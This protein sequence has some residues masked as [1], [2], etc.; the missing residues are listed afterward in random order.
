MKSSFKEFLRTTNYSFFDK[1]VLRTP[2]FPFTTS[3]GDPEKLLQLYFSSTVYQEAIFLASPSL[4]KRL[5]EYHSGKEFS[6]KEKDL[7]INAL[8]K[9]MIRMHSRCVPFGLFSGN[10]VLDWGNETAISIETKVPQRRIRPDMIVLDKIIRQ[11]ILTPHIKRELIFFPNNSIYSVRG[12]VRFVE[13]KLQ[14]NKRKYLVSEIANG[15]SVD[16]ILKMVANGERYGKLIEFICNEYDCEEDEATA[17]LDTLIESQLIVSELEPSSSGPPVL[18]TI[19]E[20]LSRV[21]SPESKVLKTLIETDS[22]FNL[23]ENDSEGENIGLY[24]DVVSK[25]LN[26]E[27][28]LTEV[29]LFQ[30]DSYIR[31]SERTISDKIQKDIQKGLYALTMLTDNNSNDN[32][33]V[34]ASKFSEVYEGQEVMLTD[35]MDSEIGLGYPINNLFNQEVNPLLDG[36]GI[37]GAQT[38]SSPQISWSPF[39][40]FLSDRI[41]TALENGEKIKE[42]SLSEVDLNKFDQNK[43]I[44]LPDTFY[45]F[46]RLCKSENPDVEYDLFLNFFAGSSGA[47]VISRFSDG[48]EEIH[49]LCESIGEYEELHKDKDSV[50]CELI[51][52]PETRNVN[53][54]KHK[55]FRSN[56]IPFLGKSSKKKSE[57][58]DINDL[59]LYMENGLLK[60]KSKSLNKNV[61]PKFSN[62]YNTSLSSIPLFRFLTD[63]RFYGRSSNLNISISS[64]ES[65][66]THLPRISFQNIILS[67]EYWILESS[68]LIKAKGTFTE[69]VRQWSEKRDIPSTFVIVQGDLE[70]PI[71]IDCPVSIFTF[72]SFVKKYPYLKICELVTPFNGVKN[73]DGKVFSNEFVAPMKQTVPVQSR[74]N[75][76]D[77]TTIK[78]TFIPGSEWLFYKIYCNPQASDNILRQMLHPI[79][80]ELLKEGKIKKWFFIRFTDPD[81]HL[82]FR[83]ELSNQSDYDYILAYCNEHFGES[84]EQSSIQNIQIAT[85]KREMERYIPS[86]IEIAEQ[87]FH[88]DSATICRILSLCETEEQRWLSG[89]FL[90]DDFLSSFG[91]TVEQKQKFAKEISERF[92][93]EFNVGTGQKQALNSR[94][95]SHSGMIEQ[96][97]QNPDESFQKISEGRRTILASEIASIKEH[98]NPENEIDLLFSYNHM[99]VNRLFRTRQRANE[100]V[101]YYF[102]HKFY[103]S[104]IARHSKV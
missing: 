78:R 20:L 25:L 54:L 82:R 36:L 60:L 71:D 47:D 10:S 33:S 39:L 44:R 11:I 24:Q 80:E 42:I 64:L 101:I 96:Q 81:Y 104:S 15:E 102:L 100:M 37:Q 57:Q 5:S 19:I 26:L 51:H 12:N 79:A 21:D 95:R 68:E 18:S 34:F 46:F 48:N 69:N 103:A 2:V 27:I 50:I 87:L 83:M 1:V 14:E 28:G 89:I 67:R 6:K 8:N 41:L 72:E 3:F 86:L 91:Y 45:T 43:N 13:F 49:Q 85:Y 4:F 98:I 92:F 90:V 58:I 55:S 22:I 7:L 77:I 16:D 59:V 94:F 76:S 66:Y 88:W 23:I 74:S 70:I 63:F 93:R 73:S 52:I 84:T 38:D 35:V 61:I 99:T 40:K 53:I 17:Y 31:L 29:N 97:M 9:Y 30:V 32:I 56:E 62:A 65:I 75:N